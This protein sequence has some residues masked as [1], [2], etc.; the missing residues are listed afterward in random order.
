MCGT[1]FGQT[2]GC[3][4][5]GTLFGQTSGCHT[6]RTLLRRKVRRAISSTEARGNGPPIGRHLP[7]ALALRFPQNML[8][9]TLVF[10]GGLVPTPFE[11]K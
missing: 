6:L 9:M 7:A 4:T 3:H 1:L 11:C 8:L 5:G 10:F 2:S